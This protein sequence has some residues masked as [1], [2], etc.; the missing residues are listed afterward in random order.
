ML[1]QERVLMEATEEMCLLMEQQG[2]S[3]SELAKR[4][5]VSPAYITKVLRGANN[6]TLRKLSDAFFDL[7]HSV[8]IGYR[9]LRSV[10]VPSPEAATRPG[11]SMHVCYNYLT[12]PCEQLVADYQVAA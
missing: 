12:E 10:A 6:F 7:G 5:G 9:P 11:R 3:K 8:H 4:M 2:I 1:E